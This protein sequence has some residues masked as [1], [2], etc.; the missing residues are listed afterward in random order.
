M[1]DLEEGVN[2]FEAMEIIASAI[3]DTLEGI[4]YL[5]KT[6][7]G[8]VWRVVGP[9][10]GLLYRTIKA[11]VDEIKQMSAGKGGFFGGLAEKFKDIAKRAHD[12]WFSVNSFK[13]VFNHYS[14]QTGLP[15]FLM[16]IGDMFDTL[17]T[18]IGVTIAAIFGLD[19]AVANGK[20]SKGLMTLRDIIAD[21]AIGLKWIYTN[22]IRPILGTLIE[23]LGNS[24]HTLGNQWKS[25]DLKG[26]LGT[27]KQIISTFTSL[28]LFFFFKIF[29]ISFIYYHLINYIF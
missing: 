20:M 9:V 27:L 17:I 26:F 19:E 6:I 13:D 23:G 29:C 1:Y 11:T 16:M 7:I 18:K 24:L 3:K 8:L 15:A 25:G 5:I 14:D 12:A 22:V 2:S 21:I 28:G 10:V 4:W